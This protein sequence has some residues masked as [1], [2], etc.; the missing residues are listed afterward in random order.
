MANIVSLE[1]MNK[2]EIA[3]V[4]RKQENP[5]LALNLKQ[6]LFVKEYLGRKNATRAWMK[7][8]NVKNYQYA[9]IAASLFLKRHPEIRDWL[10]EIEGLGTPAIA[11]VLKDAFVATKNEYANRQVFNVPDHWARMKAAEFL[12][13][14]TTPQEKAEVGNQMNV[15]I[16]MDRNKGVFEVTDGKIED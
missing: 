10:F 1:K 4:S 6:R 9:A 11:K 14:M 2:K 8:Y 16:I 13:K 7:A 5:F 3:K 15:Q 12:W